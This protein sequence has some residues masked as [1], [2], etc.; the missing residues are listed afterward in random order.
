ME[1]HHQPKTRSYRYII[2][3]VLAG[4]AAGIGFYFYSPKPVNK[5]ANANMTLFL[6]N[7]ISDIDLKLKNGDQDTDLATRL[8]WHKSNSALYEEAKSNKDK[9][10]KQQREVLRKKMVQVQQRDFPELRTAYVDSK[11]EV[12][13]Q[14]DITIAVTGANK[15]VLTFQGKMF[16]PEKVQKDFMKNIYGIIN[17]LRFKKVVYKWSEQQN[18]FADYPIDSKTDVEI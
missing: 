10:V 12:L 17:D 14:Q 11:K 15:D 1:I 3:L 4:I 16:A 13:G 9:V 7:K 5:A 6:Q 2:Y 8:S 18:S